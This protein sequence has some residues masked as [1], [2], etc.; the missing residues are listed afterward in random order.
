MSALQLSRTIRQPA[1]VRQLIGDYRGAY[2]LGIGQDPENPSQAAI[3]LQT[4][5]ADP[6]KFLDHI[7]LDNCSIR[8]IVRQ[9]FRPP[10]PL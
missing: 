2:S 7:Q 8:I 3:V 5:N 1:L 4:E 9:G 6:S 10:V